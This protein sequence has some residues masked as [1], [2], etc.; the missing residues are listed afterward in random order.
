MENLSKLKELVEKELGKIAA[1]GD[2]T[3]AEL[4][5]AT[6]AV[7]LIEK[8]KMVEDLDSGESY[9]RS[10]GSYR[11][12][13]SHNA[14]GYYSWR[15]DYNQPMDRGYSG[16]SVRDRMISQLESKMMDEAKSE[17]EKRTIE[18]LIDRLWSEK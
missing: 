3:P 1:K 2:I 7:C 13:R 12:N 11:R 18:S 9:S 6:K 5:I 15:D 10:N 16:H 8:I 17:S 14:D 4:E